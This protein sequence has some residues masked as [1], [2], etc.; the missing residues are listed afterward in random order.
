M[1]FGYARQVTHGWGLKVEG[2]K[3]ENIE[4]SI[5]QCGTERQGFKPV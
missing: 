5:P 4:H 1:S 3:K 2:Q